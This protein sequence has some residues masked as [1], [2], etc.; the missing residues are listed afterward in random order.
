MKAMSDILIGIDIGSTNIKAVA[1][2]TKG[3]MIVSYSCPMKYQTK[4]ID[5]VLMDPDY[6]WT[7]IAGMLKKIT[8]PEQSGYHVLAVSVTGMGND[9]VPITKSGEILYPMISWKSKCTTKAL[10]ELKD[11]IGL[12]RYF[13][14]TG[15][16]ARTVDSILKMIWFQHEQ[17]ERFDQIYKWLL[18]VDYINYRLCGEICTDATLA[19][20]TGLYDIGKKEWSDELLSA[21]NIKKS[22]MPVVRQSG[23]IIGNVTKEV[24]SFTGIPLGTPV[25]LGGWDIQC[26]ALALGG[27]SQNTQVINTL[28]T[29]ETL[30][31]ESGKLITGKKIF[32]YGLNCCQHVIPEK[33][34]YSVFVPS[35]S[36]VEW[37]IRN[38]YSQRHN[39]TT[40]DAVYDAFVKD[41]SQSN[42]G[43]NGMMFLP[44]IYGGYFPKH[45]ADSLGA[46]IGISSRSKRQDYTRS[47][48]EGMSYASRQILEIYTELID[49]ETAE[50]ILSGGGTKNTEWMQIKANIY[51]KNIKISTTVE[52]T[53]LGAA[54][55]AGAGIGVYK[56]L[57]DARNC[58]SKATNEVS[59]ALEAVEIYD[60][61]YAVYK[62]LYPLIK[63]TSYQ[64]RELAE[65]TK[66]RG[67]NKS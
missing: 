9:G 63:P 25:V 54:L 43:A 67:Y 26:A 38:F 40:S 7:S 14:I 29:W 45:D 10:E 8:Q 50:M 35:S 4:D 36:I 18:I 1:F 19:C 59:P 22:I 11:T 30:M 12:E 66:R 44:H 3:N 33:Y 47:M 17:K 64:L 2:D 60:Q 34:T 21:F 41:I 53:A 31:L 62:E 61:Y 5:E 39:T 49:E 46:F 37:H 65:Q 57:D 52:A 48:L 32:D 42:F 28:G 58:I 16:Q 13:E 27:S 23:E 51:K 56:S 24:S 6:I 55:L 15:I 20:T